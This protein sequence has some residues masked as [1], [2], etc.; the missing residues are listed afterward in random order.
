MDS[1]IISGK[2]HLFVLSIVDG[3]L[4]DWSEERR[5][6]MILAITEIKENM[7]NDYHAPK[8]AERTR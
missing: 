4:D 6:E 5:T 7:L 1:T 8:S 3:A 2:K